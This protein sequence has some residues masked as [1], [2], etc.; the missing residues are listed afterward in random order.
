MPCRADWKCRIARCGVVATPL[1]GSW[2]AAKCWRTPRKIRSR[3][4]Q[5]RR[6]HHYSARVDAA[7]DRGSGQCHWL[8][9]GYRLLSAPEHGAGRGAPPGKRSGTCRHG[10]RPKAAR[11]LRASMQDLV[12]ENRELPDNRRVKRSAGLHLEHPTIKNGR[13]GAAIHSRTSPSARRVGEAR[14]NRTRTRPPCP[15]NRSDGP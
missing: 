9:G 11:D 5:D 1:V 2:V 14:L 13:N 15:G 6:A 4:V 8:P 7:L 10:A 3:P 12:R